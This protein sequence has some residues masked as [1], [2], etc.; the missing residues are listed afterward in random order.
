MLMLDF[1]EILILRYKRATI[2]ISFETG[3][4]SKPTGIA[5]AKK[6]SLR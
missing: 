2:L 4:I 6:L 1:L 3:S 5:A